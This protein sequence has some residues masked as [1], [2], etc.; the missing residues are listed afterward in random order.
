MKIGKPFEMVILGDSK[1][2]VV[3]MV[4]VFEGMPL[5]REN[6]LIDDLLA[7]FIVGRQ[8]RGQKYRGDECDRKLNVG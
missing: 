6:P 4:N 8:H 5:Q 3:M 1:K 7:G 2:G